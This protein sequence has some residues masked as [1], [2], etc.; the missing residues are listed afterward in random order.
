MDDDAYSLLVSGV[1]N[2]GVQFD[3]YIAH[4]A[5]TYTIMDSG[6]GV[7]SEEYSVLPGQEFHIPTGDLFLF[8]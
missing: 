5:G 1:W 3:I 4:V 2:F 6:S 7:W 8:Y